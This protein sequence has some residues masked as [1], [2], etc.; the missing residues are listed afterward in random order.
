[1]TISEPRVGCGAAIVIDERILLIQRL[2]DPEAGAWGLPGGKV[3]LFEPVP[4][5]VEREIAEELGI[6]ILANELLCVV[7]HIDQDAGY[8]WVAPV[9]RVGAFTGE[10]RVMEPAKHS[11]VAW[12]ALDDLPSPLTSSTVAAVRALKA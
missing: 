4:R 7:D 1:M 5:A 9:Y 2:A 8:H 10:P 3:D 11:G 6:V 12:F